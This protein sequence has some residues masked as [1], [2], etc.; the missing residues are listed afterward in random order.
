MPSKRECSERVLERRMFGLLVGIWSAAAAALFFGS[1]FSAEVASAEPFARYLY[2]ITLAA[3]TAT[4]ALELMR[5]R[6]NAD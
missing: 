6:R 3:S 5:S 2:M 1:F 4:A